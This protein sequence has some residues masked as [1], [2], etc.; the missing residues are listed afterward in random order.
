MNRKVGVLLSYVLMIFEVLST[1][2]LTPFIIRTLGQAEYGVYK[3]SASINA[4][5]LLLDLGVG[6]AITRYIAKFRVTKE[7]EQERRFLGIATLYYIVIAIIALIVGAVLVA[8]LPTAFAKGLSLEEMSL[9]QKLLG[10]TM[11]NSAVTL[12]TAA[13]NNV[14]IAYEKFYISKGY[15]IVQIILR[16]VLTYIAL[17]MEMGSIGIVSVNLLMTVLCRSFFVYYVLIKLKLKPQLHGIDFSFVKEIVA[18]S[19]L[20]LLQMIATQLNSTVDQILIGSLVS[21]SSVI[22]AVY[23]VGTQI[24]Q[25]FQSIGSAFNGVLMPGVVK[26]V[27]NKGSPKQITDEMIRIGRIILIVLSLI[28]SVFLVNGQ[29]FINLWAGNDNK[30]AYFVAII[31]MTAYTLAIS[32]AIGTQ[33]LW[34]MNEHREQAYLKI[35]IVLL[36]I[37]LTILLIKWN[38][39]IGATLGTFISLMLGDVGVMNYI[40]VKKL[41]L[42]LIIYYKNLFRG[43]IICIPLSISLGYLANM[44]MPEG[45]IWFFVKSFI[46]VMFYGIFMLLFGFNEYEKGL[47]NSILANLKLK[48]GE[49]K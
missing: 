19:S 21:A 28:W 25:Y 13:Y 29:E 48:R 49:N 16:M 22:L 33:I 31:L 15:S 8:I 40:F 26:M 47:V 45:W 23:G 18:Y 38:P 20:I 2:L 9:A 1:L 3:L 41:N 44:I 36:N 4:Y 39:L 5:L 30:Q 35:T 6:N 43:I 11:I 10:I 27:E 46:M 7:K 34:A 37:L 17:K 42:N 12:G 24:V 32:Q 14:I